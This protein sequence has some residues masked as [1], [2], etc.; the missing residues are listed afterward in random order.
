MLLLFHCRS[1]GVDRPVKPVN[2]DSILALHCLNYNSDQNC[3]VNMSVS[4]RTLYKK[5]EEAGISTDDHTQLS[6]G[7]LD[8]IIQSQSP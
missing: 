4:Q 3:I 8:D 6:K 2:V 7:E 5:V 1:T